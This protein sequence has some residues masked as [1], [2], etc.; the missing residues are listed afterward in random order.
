M[1]KSVR[2]T[3]A[4]VGILALIAVCFV[5]KT[6]S[7]IFIPLVLA[8]FLAIFFVPLL[9]KMEKHRIPRIVGVLIAV[10]I[11]LLLILILSL[12]LLNTVTKFA[13]EF[14]KYQ[15]KIQGF[16]YGL[17]QHLRYFAGQL[18]ERIGYEIPDTFSLFSVVQNFQ[19]GDLISGGLNS[20]LNRS[21]SFLSAFTVLLLFLIFVMS[22]R[23]MIQDRI[24]LAFLRKD[25][26]GNPTPESLKKSETVGFIVDRISKDTLSYLALKTVISA[27]TGLCV[28]IALS[29]IGMDFVPLWVAIAFS[30]NFIPNIGSIVA[31]FII[32]TFGFAQ[33]SPDW[34][35]EKI[36]FEP[37]C[38][39]LRAA[40]LELDVG[41]CRNV[42]CG[43]ADDADKNRFGQRSRFAS[44]RRGDFRRFRRFRGSEKDGAAE[45]EGGGCAAVRAGKD[46]NKEK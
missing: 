13:V 34:G 40:F 23:V 38:R 11:L 12:F 10:L 16:Y 45:R 37:R 7:S 39:L 24:K 44:D 14:P 25:E 22:E 17:D 1:E 28:G 5:L 35:G 42:S 19:W 43:S 26:A 6:L 18:G 9:N 46:K 33:F 21:F 30:F 3:A 2:L 20:I 31:V 29:V 8:L 4:G 15:E 41:N 36:R 32:S 27:L